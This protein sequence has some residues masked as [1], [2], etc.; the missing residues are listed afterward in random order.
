MRPERRGGGYAAPGTAGGGGEGN[1]AKA[2]L[3][4]ERL[5]WGS[6]W[7]GAGGYIAPPRPDPQT[8]QPGRGGSGLARGCIAALVHAKKWA[9][10]SGGGPKEGWCPTGASRSW[11]VLGYTDYNRSRNRDLVT[12]W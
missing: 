7:R 2:T 3:L 12:D 6:G 1:W 4:R 8:G 5:L 10:V 11:V 9:A